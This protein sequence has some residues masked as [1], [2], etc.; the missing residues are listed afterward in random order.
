M[1]DDW[2]D[3]DLSDQIKFAI[4]GCGGIA[5]KHADVL[6]NHV[7]GA[8]LVA[9]CDK[10]PARVGK[11]A[12]EHRVEAYPSIRSL[13]KAKG[14]DIDVINILTPSGC[15]AENVLE[16]VA[17]GCRNVVVEKPMALV[18]DDAERMV[19][20]CDRAG[21]R[22]FVVA[23]NRYNRP[24]QAIRQA[25][26]AGRFGKIVAGTVRL[27]WCRKQ[28]YYDE[29]QWRGTWRMDGGVFAN[30]AY[31]HVD[32]L[33]WLLGEV[34]SLFAYTAR[35]LVSIEAEDTGVAALRFRDGALGILEA[36]TA[37]RPRDLEGS[38]SIL[39][40]HGAVEIGGFAANKLKVWEF[41]SPDPSDEV[42]R[43]L[44]GENPANFPAYGHAAY[45]QE[46]VRCI[47]EGRPPAVDGLE[48]VRCLRLIHAI[49]ESA[50]AGSQIHVPTFTPRNSPLGSTR[51]DP[52][53]HLPAP[54]LRAHPSVPGGNPF[55]SP[56]G[57]V[58][59]MPANRNINT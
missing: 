55:D 49:Y 53:G 36:T 57:H 4:V 1:D 38:I 47:R 23:Q 48:G 56:L 6:V 44:L 42:T 46:V 54:L 50:Q 51:V 35:R 34:D 21:T 14:D 28:A 29:S 16:A 37:T 39:G 26:L 12:H 59:S 24:I 7:P 9:V 11:F 10:D 3:T 25:I 41:D 43:Q 45:L 19:D 52:P 13:L 30:Q 31:H 40:E 22:L 15:H 58:R 8:R 20:A 27:R 2:R 17:H 33:S 32:L 18:L 5:R